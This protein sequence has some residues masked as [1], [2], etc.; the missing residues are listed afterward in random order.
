MVMRFVWTMCVVNRLG[1]SLDKWRQGLLDT[2]Y[3][4]A[5]NGPAPPTDAWDSRMQ[6]L[7]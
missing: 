1:T 6:E 5:P 2:W 7:Y 4:K 3:E